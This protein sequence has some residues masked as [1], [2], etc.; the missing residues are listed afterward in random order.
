M[1]LKPV[2]QKASISAGLNMTGFALVV[3]LKT[4]KMGIVPSRLEKQCAFGHGSF[5]L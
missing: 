5:N 3:A 2:W 1:A 4:S